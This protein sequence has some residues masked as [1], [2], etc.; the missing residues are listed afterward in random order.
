MTTVLCIG[1]DAGILEIKN[2]LRE[3]RGYIVLTAPDA[4]TGVAISRK[5]P[6]DITVLDFDMAGMEGYKAAA[7]LMKE[8]PTARCDLQRLCG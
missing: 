3:P 2:A 1:G 4:A 7:I 8:Q 6:V 5:H